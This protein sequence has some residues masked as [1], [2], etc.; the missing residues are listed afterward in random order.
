MTLELDPRSYIKDGFEIISY[1]CRNPDGSTPLIKIGKYC[2]IAVHCKFILANH[3][4]NT[5]TTFP[6]PRN[7]FNHGQGNGSGYSRGDIN[8][9]N[10]VW[11]GACVSIM[12]G[13]RI[14]NG[15]IVAAGSV[16]TRDVEP[17]AVVGG[18]PARLIKYRFPENIRIRLLESKWWDLVEI[19]E[20]ELDMWTEDIEG[21]LSTVEKIRNKDK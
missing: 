18:V 11:I 5:V 14:G 16:V 9:E 21:F 3:I 10:D 6:A 12:D 1:D 8:I 7:V 13:V 15:A 20:N 4:M 17:Y 2:S 19:H